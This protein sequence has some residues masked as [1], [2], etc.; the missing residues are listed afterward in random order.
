MQTA[1]HENGRLAFPIADDSD[2]LRC[3]FF[4]TV[5]P[6]NH[7]LRGP[8]SNFVFRF[9]N[10]LLGA[11]LPFYRTYEEKAYAVGNHIH[12]SSRWTRFFGSSSAGGGRTYLRTSIQDLLH[13][14]AGACQIRTTALDF[15]GALYDFSQVFA[16]VGRS[17]NDCRGRRPACARYLSHHQTQAIAANSR[18]QACSRGSYRSLESRPC[19]CPFRMGSD[20]SGDGNRGGPKWNGR[21]ANQP[22]KW[23]SARNALFWRAFHNASGRE[24]CSVRHSRPIIHNGC[25]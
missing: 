6:P 25:G 8:H 12:G 9:N 4:H 5:C 7:K 2:D 17:R 24:H 21:G 11:R 16:A 13:A 10:M 14:A 23:D 19:T 3:C 22:N 20:Y 15:E 1:S 18:R